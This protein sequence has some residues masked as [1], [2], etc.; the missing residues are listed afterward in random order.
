[1]SYCYY[2]KDGSPVEAGRWDDPEWAARFSQ[3]WDDDYRRV[4]STVVGKARVSTVFLPV[5]HG[6][7]EGPPIIFETMIFDY[8]PVP[9]WK[10]RWWR[11]RGRPFWYE[12]PEHQW[13]YPSEALAR[14]GH[15]RVVEALMAGRIPNAYE[16]E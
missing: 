13:R 4:A 6:F 14:E 16:E 7:G 1:M 11:F 12:T 10:R 8:D 9:R 2:D 15:R 5:D 3:L